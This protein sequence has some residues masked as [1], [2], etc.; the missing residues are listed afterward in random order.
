MRIISKL[1]VCHESL[2]L[3]HCTYLLLTYLLTCPYYAR[4]YIRQ[5]LVST[6]ISVLCCLFNNTPADSLIFHPSFNCSSPGFLGASVGF[7]FPLVSILWQLRSCPHV[8]YVEH[9]QCCCSNRF[10]FSSVSMLL[11]H[12]VLTLC[13]KTYRS[14]E[15]TKTNSWK[16]WLPSW[17]IV[18]YIFQHYCILVKC[19]YSSSLAS[20]RL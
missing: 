2:V 10:C 6:L 4:R 13:T 18:D 11:V 16:V 7:L 5:W 20:L 12:D 9:G 17:L 3:T 8:V 15:N 19:C 14:L 1:G